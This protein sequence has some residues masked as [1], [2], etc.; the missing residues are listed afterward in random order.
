MN[1]SV[2]GGRKNH[3]CISHEFLRAASNAPNKVAVIHALGGA[4]IAGQL[5][6]RTA[7]SHSKGRGDDADGLFFDEVAKSSHRRSTGFEGDQCFTFS[8]LLAA[9]DSLS[10]SLRRILD[11]GDDPHLIR[12]GGN[13]C[14]KSLHAQVSVP[15]NPFTSNLKSTEV[16]NRIVPKILGVYMVPS[17][18]YIVAVLSVLRCG[19]AF[20]PLDLSWPKERIL[21]VV[22]SSNVQLILSCRSSSEGSFCGQLDKSH[23]LWDSVSCPVY[24]VSMKES[25]EECFNLSD[26][27]WPCQSRRPRLFCYSMYTSGSTGKP[28]GVCGTEDGLLNRFLWMQESYPLFGEELLLFKTSISF[29]DH[30]QEF[31]G[32]ILTTCTLVIPPFNMLKENPFYLIDFLQV[33]SINRL[34]AVPSLMKAILPALQSPSNLCMH[35]SLKLLV[36][37]GEVLPLSLWDTLSKLLPKTSILNLYGSTE[38]SGDCTYFDCKKLPMIL[39]T[40]LLNSVP[41][42]IPISNCDVVLV[43]ENDTIGDG[44]IYVGG[45]CVSV[46][47]VSDST[48]MSMDYVY[49]HKDSFCNLSINEYG[50]GLYYRTGDFARRLQSGDLVFMGRND[51][52]VKVNGQRISL[53]EIENMLRRHP[54]VL[55]AAVVYHEGQGELAVIDAFIVPQKKNL[56]S[57]I[58]RFSIRNWMVDK[59]P[60]S[61]IPQHFF[62][63]ES[64]PLSSAGKVDYSALVGSKSSVTCIEDDIYDFQS[65]DLLKVIKKAFSDA[66]MVEKFSDDDDF[67]MMGGNS[68]AAAHASHCLSIDMRLL[69]SFPSPSKLLKALLNKEGLHDVDHLNADWKVKVKESKGNMIISFDSEPRNPYRFVPSEWLLRTSRKKTGD[70]SFISKHLKMDSDLY[71]PLVGTSRRDIY[72]WNSN[73]VSMSCSFSR[74][75]KVLYEGEYELNDVCQATWSAEFPKDRQGYM[76]ELWKV[77]MNS[78]VDASPIVVLKNGDIFLFIGSHSQSF[79][80]VNCKSGSVQWEVKLEGRIECTAAIP[81]DF[82]MVIVG[83]YKGKIYFLDFSNGDTCWIFQTDGEVKSQPVTDLCRH[84]VW[85]GSHDQNLYALDYRKYQCVYKLACGGSIYGSPAIDEVHDTLYVASTSGRVTALSVKTFKFNIL[86]KREFEVPV[87]GSLAIDSLYGNVICCLVDGNVVALDASGSIVWKVFIC[88]RNGSVYSFG[89]EMGNLLWEYNVGDPITASAYVDENLELLS[90]SPNLSDRLVCIC[91]SSGSIHLLRINV[92]TSAETSQSETVVQEFARLDL[93][94]D[95]FSSPVMV[96]GRIFVGCRDDYVHCIGLELAI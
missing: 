75:N 74:C 49:L 40:E 76:R 91:A 18:E 57:E 37:S 7:D 61:M 3:C 33:Y 92:N 41:I 72:L 80:C 86:W 78:C 32:A 71:V 64:F 83:C 39:E 59:L 65:S 1:Q 21:S 93:P 34:I 30:L 24:C 25:L 22:S 26:F 53:D 35:S 2:S 79:L 17:V 14:S 46:G 15:S 31:L 90:A 28:K 62:F 47:Y 95:I 42:G 69:Y 51:R 96:G 8:E 55:D 27:I 13:L 36:L 45:I 82:S 58:L 16:E 6:S 52:I 44:E 73:S 81:G 10:C 12:P 19:E 60:L 9:V 56:A 29:I 50:R 4:R 38:V 66:L 63:M 43:G 67:F 88:S 23:W 5:Q 85:C 77:H 20:L 68:I 54:N 70:H 84:L 89:L 48:N 87:F 94:A 11:G